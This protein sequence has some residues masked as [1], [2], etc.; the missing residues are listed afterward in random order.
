MEK[1]N[2]GVFMK[3]WQFLTTIGGL[4]VALIY[5]VIDNINSHKTI[6]NLA[7]SNKTLT[8]KVSKLEGHTEIVD[9]AV[10]LFMMNPPGVLSFRLD[11]VERRLFGEQFIMQNNQQSQDPIS[12]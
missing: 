11:R 10:K 1:D 12:H 6:A 9:N 4:V 5:F 7:E 2:I 3:Y 8:E